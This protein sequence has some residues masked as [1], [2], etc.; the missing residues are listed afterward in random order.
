MKNKEE[1][2]LFY[3]TVTSQQEGKDLSIFLLKKQLIA[4]ANIL[5]RHT[6]LYEWEG[7]IEEGSEHVLIIK[8]THELADSVE[9][10]VMEN[11]SYDC[12][13][14]LRLPAQANPAFSQWVQ[15]MTTDL[16]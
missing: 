2:V 7:K 6:A 15:D 3:I 1:V 9:Q 10:E 11:Q 4:C 13:C 5:P 12:P 8:T 14:I 16:P